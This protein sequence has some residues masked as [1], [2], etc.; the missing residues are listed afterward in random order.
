VSLQYRSAV[1]VNFT[2]DADAKSGVLEAKI[3][4]TNA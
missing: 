2:L 3:D 1:F 4:S